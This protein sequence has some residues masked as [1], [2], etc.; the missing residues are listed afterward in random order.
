MNMIKLGKRKL[1]PL[2]KIFLD[3]YSSFLP[4]TPK[5]ERPNNEYLLKVPF[6]ACPDLSGGFRGYLLF[7]VSS[8]FQPEQ[9]NFGFPPDNYRGSVFRLILTT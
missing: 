1:R 5:G 9:Q 3:T 6:R 2:R 7:G 4:L 8:K